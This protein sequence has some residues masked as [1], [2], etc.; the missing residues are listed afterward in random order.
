MF[1]F[2]DEWCATILGLMMLWVLALPHIQDD[3]GQPSNW[4]G[5]K[6]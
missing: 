3:E 1:R 6:Q 4:E 5:W 2:I